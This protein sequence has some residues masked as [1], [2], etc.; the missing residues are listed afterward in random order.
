LYSLN[1][2][3]E[4]GDLLAEFLRQATSPE[5]PDRNK[6]TLLGMSPN[7]PDSGF[8]YLSPCPDSGLGMRPTHRFGAV[9]ELAPSKGF[10][11]C[12]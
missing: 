9:L 8:G 3:V 2:D 11:I 4:D 12:G 7:A 5:A 10:V 6:L 1:H